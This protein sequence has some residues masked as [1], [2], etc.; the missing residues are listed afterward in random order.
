M[1]KIDAHGIGYS[2]TVLRCR[3]AIFTI[4]TIYLDQTT[5]SLENNIHTLGGLDP[6]P[7]HGNALKT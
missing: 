5:G 6:K 1:T 2:R 3:N 4:N 7:E